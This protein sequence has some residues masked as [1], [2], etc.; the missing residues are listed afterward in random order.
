MLNRKNFFLAG[1]LFFIYGHCKS[2]FDNYAIC[3][4]AD[5]PLD[6]CLSPEKGMLLLLPS[7]LLCRRLLLHAPHATST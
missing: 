7:L 2:L 4:E 3:S 5:L 1:K 6:C